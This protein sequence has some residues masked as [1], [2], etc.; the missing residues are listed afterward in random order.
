MSNFVIL[1]LPRSR[2][3]WLSNFMNYSGI[4]CVHE[5]LN[6][7][8]SLEE[9]GKLFNGNFGDCNTGLALFDFRKYLPD[10]LKIVIID[11]DIDKSVEFAKIEFNSDQTENMIKLYNNLTNLDG[12]HIKLSELNSKLRELWEYITD[13]PFDS[14]RAK[15]LVKLNIQVLDVHDYDVDS[16]KILVKNYKND[17]IT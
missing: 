8:E 6:G 14:D 9:Y 13:K 17:Y 2:T 4:N 3:A 10:D 5:G 1:G 12:L 11:T 15:R 7:I 16:I